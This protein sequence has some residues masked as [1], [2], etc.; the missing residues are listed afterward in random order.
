MAATA[1]ADVELPAGTILR[2]RVDQPVDIAAGAA[3]PAS[4]TPSATPQQ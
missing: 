4:V 1:G 2:I 3:T